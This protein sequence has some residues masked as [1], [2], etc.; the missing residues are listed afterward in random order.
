MQ[1]VHIEVMSYRGKNGNYAREHVPLWIARIVGTD[2][3][4]RRLNQSTWHGDT[5]EGRAMREAEDWASF[6]GVPIRRVEG[7]ELLSGQAPE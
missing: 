2:G 6:F 3:S 1:G 7:G 5:D 4:K